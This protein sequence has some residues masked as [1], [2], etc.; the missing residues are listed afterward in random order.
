MNKIG[1]VYHLDATTPSVQSGRPYSLLTELRS[2]IPLQNIFPLEHVSTLKRNFVKVWSAVRGQ[3]WLD[4]R[5]EK[6][7]RSFAT[8]IER[9]LARERP[10]LLF[11]PSTLPFS[12]LETDLPVTFCADAPFCAMHNYYHAFSKLS[13]AQVRFS[14]DLESSVLQRSSLSIYP[15]QWAADAAIEAY[16]APPETVKV[17]PFG[18]NFGAENTRP[19]VERWI[20]QRKVDG[21]IRLLFIGRDWPRKGGDLTLGIAKWLSQQGHSVRLDIVGIRPPNPLPAFAHWH[22]PLRPW[23]PVERSTLSGLI[24]GAHFLL[25]PSREEAYGMT[26]CEAN[27][28]GV[29]VVTTQT[30]GITEIVKPGRNGVMLPLP[31]EAPAYGERILEMISSI[32]TYRK[33]A[34]TSFEEF[35]Q[36]LNWKSFG[37]SYLEAAKA[38]V[39]ARAARPSAVEPPVSL[40][41]EE[42]GARPLRVLYVSNDYYDP[43]NMRSWSGLPR[44]MWQA[45]ERQCVELTY[46][47]LQ[48]TMAGR[49]WRSARSAIGKLTG[50]RFLRDRTP[51][52]LR[53]YARQIEQGLALHEP[54]F[55]FCPGTAPIAFL[56]TKTP[57]CFWVDATFAGMVDY[58]DSF[59]NLCQSSLRAGA[60]VDQ[61]ALDRATLALY[62]SEWAAETALRSYTVDSERVHVVPFG[63]NLSRPPSDAEVEELIVGRG[64][65]ECRLFLAGVDWQRKGANDAV[66]ILQALWEKGIPARLTIIGCTPPAGTELPEGVEVLGFVDKK[67]PKGMRQI[68][69]LFGESH[70]FVLPTKAEAYGLVLCEAA[71]FG[72]P[73]LT[74]RSGGIPSIIEDGATGLLFD[75]AAP[76][77]EYAA[78]IARIWRQEKYL[79]MARAARKT[80]TRRLNWDI[81]GRRVVELMHQM[82]KRPGPA[83]VLTEA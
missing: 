18:A 64:A 24:Q 22:G 78:G 70:F 9:A 68:E 25:M 33:I 71:A 76:P 51:D 81:A 66:K 47:P 4:D 80:F 42:N 41:T 35:E 12:Y 44:F 55:I 45:L 48:E 67:S 37:A 53:S 38:A 17:V 27:A 1:Y 46:M 56:K 31:A 36:R 58:Y 39:L 13:A 61:A 21:E 54:D 72:L 62:S 19:E 11:S 8:Q 77:E 5:H 83:G 63:A 15:S 7:L 30:G 10:D 23:T 3:H 49:A 74:A 65:Q 6:L 20:E 52:L 75:P 34:Q 32:D 82:K 60:E 26:L 16:G 73:A 2:R 29:P 59:S 69:R 43:R 79:E 57:I 40:S 28:F 50:R 14:E